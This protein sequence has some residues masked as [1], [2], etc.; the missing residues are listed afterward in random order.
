MR[1]E[2]FIFVCSVVFTLLFYNESVGL[3]LSLFGLVILALMYYFY[4]KQFSDNS[5]YVLTF[6]SVLSCLAFAWYGDFVSFLAVFISI[7]LLQFKINEPKLKLLLALPIVFIN[8]VA[9]IVRIFYFSDWLP[10]RKTENFFVKKL[11]AYFLIPGIVLSL[12]CIIYSFGSD[13]FSGLFFKYTLD[14]NLRQAIFVVVLGFYFSFSF[15]N[16]WVPEIIIENNSKLDNDFNDKTGILQ[17]PTFS[18][19]DLDVNFER[20][21]GEITLFFLNGLLILFIVMYNYEQFFQETNITTLSAA[22][23]ERVNAVV[24]SIIMA[25]GVVLFYFKGGFNFDVKAKRLKVLTKI[26]I[27]L[28]GL[29]ILS[30]FI[31]NLEYVLNFGLTYKRLGVFAFLILALI[32]LYLT[33]IKIYKKKTNAFLFNQMFL[34]FYSTLLLCSFVNWGGIITNYNISMNRGVEPTFLSRLNYNDEARRTYFMKKKLDGQY[35]EISRE[36]EIEA[37][38]SESFLSKVLYYEFINKE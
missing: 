26:W 14:L 11:I 17:E 29:L 38:Q 37:M 22:T 28:N 3:N 32:G 8:S 35:N 2:H 27:L 23:H 24:F 18:L 10:A 31:K 12:F 1:K 20:K 4:R 30:T 13:S 21:S 9:S 16:F 7:I 33:F 5:Y 19:L 6:T 34:C 25:V 15:W 36:E